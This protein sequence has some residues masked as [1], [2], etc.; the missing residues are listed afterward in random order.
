[1][2][3]WLWVHFGLI[4]LGL[5]GLATAVGS[6]ALYLWQSSQLKSKRPGAIFLKLPS[7]DA[8]DRVHY[9]A[10]II[11]VAF[12]SLGILTGFFWASDIRA[13]GSIWRD[14]K[15]SLSF[16]TCFLLW[17]LAGVRIT[18]IRRGQKIAVGTLIVFALLFLTFFSSYYAPSAFHQGF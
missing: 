13:M 15:V 4:L 14:L 1:M 12:F 6:A 5:A 3:P 16:L 7:L 2:S 17:V 9:R 18:T 11:G 8:L 10:L